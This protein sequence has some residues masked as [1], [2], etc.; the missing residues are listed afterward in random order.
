MKIIVDKAVCSGHARCSV[1][2]PSVYQLDD[3]GYCGITEAEVPA[4]LEDDAR[5]GAENCPERAIAIV[6]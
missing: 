1:F 2:A 6:D 5:R 4:G 3:R